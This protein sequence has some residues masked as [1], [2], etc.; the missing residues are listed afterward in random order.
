MSVI[1]VL[2][3]TYIIPIYCS[4]NVVVRFLN[5]FVRLIELLRRLSEKET[6]NGPEKNKFGAHKF[7]GVISRLRP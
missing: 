3:F 1:L 6:K 7:P 4:V 5:V 2:V